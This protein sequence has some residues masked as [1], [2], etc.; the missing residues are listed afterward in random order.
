MKKYIILFAV[1]I[2]IIALC[3]LTACSSEPVKSQKSEEP[4]S[5]VAPTAGI[6][7]KNGNDDSGIQEAEKTAVAT[8]ALTKQISEAVLYIH[9]CYTRSFDQDGNL[10][11]EGH[12][13]YSVCGNCSKTGAW[14]E[15]ECSHCGVRFTEKNVTHEYETNIVDADNRDVIYS[16]SYE[17]FDVK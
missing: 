3:A 9:Y 6:D 4:V 12:V 7:E 10:L 8:P 11:A 17:P 13:S 16:V 5:T 1:L 2:L 14:W 15:E